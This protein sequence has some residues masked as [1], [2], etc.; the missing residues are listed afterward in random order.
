MARRRKRWPLLI[1][2]TLLA[3]GAALLL[4]RP[5]LLAP[6]ATRL[7]NRHLA[8]LDGHLQVGAY[9][10]RALGGLDALDVT[11]TVRGDRGGLTLVA[12]DTLAIDFRLRDVLQR[13]VQFRRVAALGVE[14]YH[15]QT[16]A[17]AVTGTRGDWPR[18]AID[19]VLIRDARME[20][21]DGDGRLRE[22]IDDL[23]WNGEFALGGRRLRAV[24]HGGGL[25]WETRNA[26]LA[27]I[28][29]MITVDGEETRIEMLS[30][31]WND[32]RV[33][34]SGRHRPSL[35]QV[36]VSGRNIATD[37][38]SDLTGVHLD[39]EARGD[40]NGNVVAVN[41]TVH[42]AADFTGRLEAWD[43]DQV[44]GEA[45]ICDDLVDFRVLRGGIN[46][47]TFAG[48]LQVDSRGGQAAVITLRGE[49]GGLDL[50]RGLVPDADDL[51]HTGGHGNIEVVH[52]TGDHATRVR[53]RLQD[54]F[55]EFMPFDHCVVDVWARGDSLHFHEVSLLRGSV[56]ASLSGASDRNEVFAGSLQLVAADL[57]DVPADWGWPA[58][59]GRCGG[60]FRVVGPLPDLGVIGRLDFYDLA[61]GALAAESGEVAV[62]GER[63]L[64]DSWALAA[65]ATGHGF[66]L[67]GVPLGDFKGRLRADAASVAVDSFRTSLGDTSLVVRGRADLR[68]GQTELLVTDLQLALPGSEWHASGPIGAVVAPGRCLLPHLHLVSAQGELAAQV[69]YLETGELLDGRLQ[70]TNV[71]LDLLDAMIDWP[72]RT[73]GRITAL[74]EFGGRPREPAINLRG[75][76][77]HAVFPLAR[78]DSL[79]IAANLRRGTVHIDTLSLGSDYGEVGLRGS[80]S[81][82]DADL[83]EFWPGAALDVELAIR[84]GDW[85]FLEQFELPALDRLAGR[86]QGQLSLRGTTLEPLLIGDLDCAPFQFQWLRLER[87]TGTL[88]ADAAQLALGDLRGRHSTL[89]LEGRVEIP[90]RFDLLSEPLTPEDGPFFGYLRVPPGTDLAPL[91]YATNAFRRCAGRG[92]AEMTVSGPLAHPQYQGRLAVD[93]VEIMLRDAEELFHDCRA[94]GT[95][96]GDVLFLPEIRGRTGLRGTFTGS[97]QVAFAGLE[98]RTWDIAFQADRALV[99]TIPDLRA[100]V[101]TT[102]GRL[103]GVA[104]G[105]DSTLV[106][107]FTGDYELIRGRYTGNFAGT[108]GSQ[109]PTLGNIAPDWLADL[110]ITGAPR[111]FRISNRTMELD[112]S[113]DVSLVRDADG[114]TLSGTGDIDTGRLPVFHNTF[115]VTRGSLDFSREVGVVPIVDIDAETRVRLSSPVGGYSVVERL[116]VHAAGPA[117]AM[118]ITYSSESGY[119]REAI[120]RMLLGMAPYPDEQG[121]QSALTSASIGAGLNLLEREIARGIGIFDT[122]E[123]DQIQRQQEGAT[124]LDPLIGVGKYVGRD[125][126][127]K[128][129]QGLNQNHYDLLLEYQITN[130]LLLQTEIRRRID[131]YQGDATYNLDFKYR[132]EY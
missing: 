11:L 27:D 100:L 49:A 129:A 25:R 53:G 56:Q 85:A 86:F 64:G 18:L 75:E 67:G 112:L 7:I 41:D 103:T 116:T 83:R 70:L 59:S 43:L 21:S 82:P 60:F 90:L 81:H 62:A 5:E 68:D 71:D 50:R 57:R 16:P 130:H 106:P 123:I 19:Q 24:T 111:T 87:L 29:G 113:G 22:S 121:D 54:G 12:V 39:L 31:V 15:H 66:A 32:G 9:R 8:H 96:D 61:G 117:D 38:F 74:I 33:T 79:R 119:P 3:A 77:R 23:H 65:A 46:G 131:E 26:A 124:G 76:L 73:G 128:Y 84:D 36:T 104:V 98:L 17:P 107:R 95:F 30:A 14:I 110:R 80:I 10:L 122:F 20:I 109:D 94:R 69:D 51:P 44:H 63:V 40:L 118:T 6:A 120:E 55:I 1:A 115:K 93:D 45:I 101:R 52:T 89:Q 105:P 47:A 114:M 91:L 13:T 88:R 99:A 37:E 125:L 48:S 127:I 92:E 35:L 78:I 58:L 72:R 2:A 28:Y 102:N 126:Y 34:V 4:S 97:G 108:A 42:F 132:V